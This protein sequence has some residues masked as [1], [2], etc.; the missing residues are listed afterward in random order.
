MNSRRLMLPSGLRSHTINPTRGTE[1]VA[2]S[3]W[4]VVHLLP[5]QWV[6]PAG[7]TTAGLPSLTDSLGNDD[8]T[9][10]ECHQEIHA[11]QQ[12]TSYSISSSARPSKGTGI[13]MPSALAAFRLM[14][15]SNLVG[16]WTGSS[17]GLSP[18][19]IRI[20]IRSR[21]PRLVDKVGAVGQQA[22]SI[23]VVSRSIN[24]RHSMS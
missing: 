20:D 23:S 7:A 10:K 14:T 5:F 4:A 17:P 2:A 9:A 1:A 12:H 21:A 22:A 3:Q 8:A 13:L 6:Y 15:N 18:L 19:R 16:D 11:A 24:C